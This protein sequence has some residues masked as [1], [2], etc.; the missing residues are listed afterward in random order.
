[1][2]EREGEREA[3]REAIEKKGWGEEKGPR[4]KTKRDNREIEKRG[5]HRLKVRGVRGRRG[6][7][8]AS[9][10]CECVKDLGC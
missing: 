3:E 1:V 6:E 9:G 4:E 5:G 2:R 10:R 8:T 7:P